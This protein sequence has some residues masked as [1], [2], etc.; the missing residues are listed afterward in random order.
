MSK[1]NQNK[2]KIPL[3]QKTILIILGFF[4]T[5]IILEV[6]LRLGGFT[7]LSLQES[8]NRA[9]L[10]QKSTYRIL[11][12][13]ESTTQQQWPPLLEDILNQSNMGIKFSVIDKGI[14]GTTTSIILAKLES[15]LNAY[16]PDIV[17]TMMGINDGGSHLPY[18]PVLNSKGMNFL[19]SF[20]IYKLTKLLWLHIVIRLKEI[21]SYRLS[22]HATRIKPS[23]KKTALRQLDAQKNNSDSSEESLRLKKAIEL[24]P[25]NAKAHTALV[26]L[27][28][29]QGKFSEAEALFKKTIELNPGSAEAHIELAWLYRFQG[30]L[31]EAEA[32]FKKA[33]E[34]NPG[35]AKAHT[36]L[37]WLYRFQ[38]KLP[39]AE[40]L[41]KKYIELNPG[42]EQVCAELEVVYET[43]GKPGLA[44]EYGRK[45]RELGLNH[46][47]P[48]TTA[49]YHKLRAILD[50][51]GI[52]YVCV[53]YPMRPL[54]TLKMIFE[55]QRNI[56]FVDNEKV[57]KDAI[58]K[59][60][61]CE[62]FWDM[63]GG[64]F[65][66][67]TEKGNRLLAENIA[68]VILKEV[69]KK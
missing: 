25:G 12:L 33:I 66:H 16:Q 62:Y 67:C 53:Q 59:D 13:G 63:F 61:Y 55:G 4:L 18:E 65:G 69:F 68:N 9:S 20:R 22:R 11:C 8:K 35:S 32:L 37:A 10:K 42:N 41:L 17:I 36:A 27:Y 3:R 31:P 19:K 29:D 56:I 39:E 40:E 24:N 51:K 34:L 15:N 1:N 21:E 50:K 60:G 54:K 45:A 46:Y 5:A 52:V 30:K 64:D 58:S 23:L 2:T 44:I 7:L 26:K 43:M 49:N 14:V 38:G 57:F 47:I 6:G 48:I 28:R